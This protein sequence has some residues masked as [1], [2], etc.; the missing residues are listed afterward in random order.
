[1][2]KHERFNFKGLDD[3]KEKINSL[4]LQ[5]P[6]SENLESL[7]QPVKIGETTIANAISVHPME[8][9]DG[10]A[11]G[12]PDELTYRR[13]RRFASGGAGLLWLEATA[14][15]HEGRANPLQLYL[16]QQNKDAFGKLFDT[17]I[18]TAKAEFGQNHRVYTVVQLTHSGRYS[19][20]E[21]KPAPVIAT[22]NPYLGRN[23]PE[24]Y[25]VISDDQL[26]QLEDYFLEAAVLARDIGFDAVDIKACHGYLNSELLSAFT[27]DGKYGG[28]F[29][30]RTR[31]L[32]N[33]VDKI[34]DRLGDSLDITLRLNAYDAVPY[35]YGWGVDRDDYR[36]PDLSEPIRLLRILADKG[37]NMVN[38]S[39]GNPYYNPHIGR[40]YDAGPYIPPEH[41]LEG[42]ARMLGIIRDIQQSVPDMAVIST[43]LSWLRHLSPFAAAGGVEEGWFRIAGFGR[44]AFAYPQF[45]RDI[46]EKGEL[47]AKRS[48]IACGKCTEIMRDGGKAGCVIRD[49]KIYVPIYKAGREGKPPIQS[50]RLAEHV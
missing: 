27:R 21:G 49:N 45:P 18:G 47:D 25:P 7:A 44:L 13:Y 41:P 9:C 50:N 22:R 16:C 36:K 3:L 40:P 29:E 46:F 48:C 1:M 34:K 35:P 20:P 11:E 17:I 12:A 28:S 10:T 24:D 5:I 33:I 15:V 31:F 42:V 37:V 6:I 39:C 26:E 43:G 2:N 23:L 14:V 4:G 30:N 8:G 38:I 32:I 19:K